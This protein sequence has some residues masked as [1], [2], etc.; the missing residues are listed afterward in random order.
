MLSILPSIIIGVLIYKADRVEQ[1]PKI[2]LIKALLMGVLAVIITYILSRV[3]GFINLDSSYFNPI[4]LI[5]YSFISV[6]FIEEFSKW[7]C[8]NILLTKNKNYNYLFDGIVYAVF[9]SLGFATIENVLYNLSGG[10]VIALI[11]G[12]ITVP[13]HAFYA[14]FMG[15]YLS[16]AKETKLVGKKRYSLKYLS[17]SLLIP[18][19]FHGTFDMLLLLGNTILLFAFLVFIL[20][21]Y[22][23]SLQKVKKLSNREKLFGK[24]SV[25]YCLKCG[26]KVYNKTC[27][28]CGKR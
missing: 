11:R 19:L 13:S 25:S 5:L 9:V 17:Y 18:I 1:E 2:E 20:F 3:F 6:A 26:S 4:Q 28:S 23:I 10:V 21:L 15:Y 7:L 12:I 27:S 16:L 24:E 14:I 22:A 8:L